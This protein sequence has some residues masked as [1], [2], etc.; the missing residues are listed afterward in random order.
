MGIRGNILLK[1]MGRKGEYLGV[2]CG[3]EYFGVGGGE[4][5][6]ILV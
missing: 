3:E 2:K 6:N 5:K 1:G 4:E